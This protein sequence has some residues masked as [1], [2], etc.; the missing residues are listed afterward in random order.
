[1]MRRLL[2]SSGIIRACIWGAKVELGVGEVTW[3]ITNNGKPLNRHEKSQRATLRLL[4]T[5]G[6]EDQ[7]GPLLESVA[8][9]WREAVMQCSGLYSFLRSSYITDWLCNRAVGGSRKLAWTLDK[10]YSKGHMESGRL[11]ETEEWRRPPTQDRVLQLRSSLCI[12]HTS[13][14]FPEH[15]YFVGTGT[16]LLSHRRPLASSW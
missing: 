11:G 14:P 5:S 8:G 12:S 1:M 4:H 6:G 3:N 13:P 16:L 7:E 10:N 2:F 15:L 9:E